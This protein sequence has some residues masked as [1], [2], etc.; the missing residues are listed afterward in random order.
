MVLSCIASPLSPN[1]REIWFRALLVDFPP[2][3]ICVESTEGERLLKRC[4]Y[5]GRV[6]LYNEHTMNKSEP[7]LVAQIKNSSHTWLVSDAGLTCVGD[8]G[9]Q[10]VREC[11]RQGVR[12]TTQGVFSAILSAIVMSGCDANRFEYLGYPPRQQEQRQSWIK[13]LVASK[14]NTTWAAIETPYRFLYL[15]EDCISLLPENAWLSVSINVGLEG[16]Q[17]ISKPIREWS[18]VMSLEQ[19]LGKDP[20]GVVV[21]SLA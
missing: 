19:K 10:L 20:L 15:L 12:V 7:E 6:A 21:F 1:Q 18:G 16:H 14:K 11:H 5:E 3:F 13:D 8:P 9:W 2:D 17:T 4:G